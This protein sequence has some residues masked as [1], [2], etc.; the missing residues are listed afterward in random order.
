MKIESIGK[1]RMKL[2]NGA[3]QAF[4]SKASNL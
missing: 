3:I 4:H 2:R 1:V